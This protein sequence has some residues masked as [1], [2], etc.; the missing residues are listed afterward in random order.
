VAPAADVDQDPFQGEASSG[1]YCTV[2]DLRDEGITVSM[3]SDA[4]ALAKIVEQSRYLDKVCRQWFEPRTRTFRVNG[5]G[6]RV[7]RLGVPIIRLDSAAYVSGAGTDFDDSDTIEVD[8]L[9][10]F[11]RHLTQ[12]LEEPDDRDTPRVEF[13]LGSQ[14]L[15][16]DGVAYL[17]SNAAF[18]LS[19]QGV[20][21]TGI[22]GYT[23]LD[24]DDSV[25]ETSEG[26]QVPLAYGRTP[27]LIKRAC[28]LLVLRDMPRLI[29]LDEREDY[30]GRWMLT[31]E[32]TAD[33]SYT[34]AA[35][36]SVGQVGF[37]TGDPRIDELISVYV[38]AAGMVSSSM[39]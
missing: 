39:G 31:G 6:A 22:F 19:T 15:G 1:M 38:S 8:D 5:R 23:E 9:R 27:P 36:A 35:P 14:Y 2:Q 4:R 28:L 7:L 24:P 37:W 18:G 10:V 20:Q 25:G 29:D 34:R 12:G 13:P 33:Q 16:T 30:A 3:L 32:R 26:S 11:N 21:L 17:G